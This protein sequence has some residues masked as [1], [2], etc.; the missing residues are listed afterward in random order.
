MLVGR[1]KRKQRERKTVGYAVRTM[2]LYSMTSLV[3]HGTLY[4]IT[5]LLDSISH[6]T[7][8]KF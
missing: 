3:A 5:I 6:S 8:F 7:A 4:R 2:M 1:K